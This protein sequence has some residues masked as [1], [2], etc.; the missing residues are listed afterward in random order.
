LTPPD[1]HGLFL[2]GY[3]ARALDVSNSVTIVASLLRAGMSIP[4]G[5]CRSRQSEALLALALS[6]TVTFSP[7]FPAGA[8]EPIQPPASAADIVASNSVES[9]RVNPS[10]TLRG[11]VWRTKAGIVFLKTPIGLLTLSSKTTLKDLRA[12]HDVLFWVHERNSVVDIRKKSEG[13]L[14]HR[15][16]TGP[17]TLGPDNSKTMRWWTPEG[18]E[19]THF[20]TQEERLG[21]FHEGDILTV[22][23]DEAHTI[24]GVHDLQYDLQISQVPPTGSQAQVLLSGTVSKLKSNFVFF[25]TPV[26]LVMVNSKIGIP[27]VKVGQSMTLQIDNQQITVDIAPAT[28]KPSK[29]SQVPTTSS[30]PTP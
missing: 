30:A 29:N 23:V 8:Q 10:I 20:G 9:A 27:Q 24:I 26:G 28:A 11:S 4:I 3:A 14:V 5:A 1:Y 7:L 16:L 22:E 25:R 21:G 18:E 17:M 13:G 15:Y 12:S 6:C 19:T 2:E